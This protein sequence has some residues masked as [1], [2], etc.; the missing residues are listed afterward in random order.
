MP[1]LAGHSQPAADKRTGIKDTGAHSLADRD[2]DQNLATVELRIEPVL[3]KR[4]AVCVLLREDRD[5]QP[6]SEKTGQRNVVPAGGSCHQGDAVID[7]AVR[8]GDR[9]SA[10]KDPAW[11][12]VP[13]HLLCRAAQLIE[14]FVCVLSIR[15]IVLAERQLDRRE[16]EDTENEMRAGKAYAQDPEIIII[17]GD[18]D[19]AAPF[20]T[21]QES[22]FLDE[23]P[24][25]ELGRDV[26]DR[27]LLQPCLPGE[28]YSRTDSSPTQKPE[29]YRT[30]VIN[31][32]RLIESKTFTSHNPTLDR[33]LCY[34]CH[35]ND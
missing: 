35:E 31:D 5:P 21:G 2:I 6:L 18:T 11:R 30:V 12:I 22:C 13:D 9:D 4:S 15:D 16:I 32:I 3:C 19:R 26:R 33:F 34:G 7:G 8:P 23:S 20:A 24:A 17:K 28:F 25:N 10:G 1:D 14:G 29:E 27:R